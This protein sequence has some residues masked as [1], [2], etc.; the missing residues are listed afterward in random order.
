MANQYSVNSMQ[1]EVQQALNLDI[2]DYRVEV[3]DG[4]IEGRFIGLKLKSVFQPIYDID[5]SKSFG[6]E[7]L[8]RAFDSRGEAI[9]PLKAF[10]QSEIAG[11]LIKFDRVCRTLH[12]LNFLNLSPDKGRLFLNVHPQ[13]LVTV[14][15]H[16]KVFERVLH[17][18]S[19]ST[20]Q[21]VI[22][23]PES[24]VEQED[25]LEYAIKNYR[26][27]GYKIAIDNFGRDHTSLERLWRLSPDFV[28]FDGSIIQ[29]A[30]TNI[31]LQKVLPRLVDIVRD[32]GG[33]AIITG[34]ETEGQLEL[35]RQAGASLVQGYLLGRADSALS[36]DDTLMSAAQLIAQN[37]P[38]HSAN[39]SG[40]IL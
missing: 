8:L 13:L 3:H 12:T 23:I 20:S 37:T 4:D 38:H 5:A 18:Y 30:E 22:E 27:R 39:H 28:K 17:D 32:L 15:S 7:A 16:G 25:L 35:A 40:R 31:R 14:N 1:N 21:V 36:W 33:Q 19:L 2:D 34:V 11:Q 26:E 9:S 24:I 29:Q 10:V 6:Y